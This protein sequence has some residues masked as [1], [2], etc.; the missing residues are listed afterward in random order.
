MFPL[1]TVREGDRCWWSHC[2]CWGTG[3]GGA[4]V[5]GQVLVEPLGLLNINM[6]T[7]SCAG[8]L[9][10]EVVDLLHMI[11]LTHQ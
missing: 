9:K 4:T 1:T 2:D 11:I 5:G 7:S 10:E 8:P 3:A 6:S